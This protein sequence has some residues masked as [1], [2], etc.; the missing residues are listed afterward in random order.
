MELAEY[1]VSPGEE[2][3]CK[4]QV[5]LCCCKFSVEGTVTFTIENNFMDEEVSLNQVYQPNSPSTNY[6]IFILSIFF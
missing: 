2:K 3:T 4:D 1:F 6:V 5:K